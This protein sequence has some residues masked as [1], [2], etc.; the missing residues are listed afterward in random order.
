MPSPGEVQVPVGYA[1][2][3]VWYERRRFLPAI[4]S[5]SFCAVL[6]TVQGGL[7]LGMLTL[8]SLAIDHCRADVWIGYPGAS[9]TDLGLPIP[10]AWR[11]HLEQYPEIVRTETYLIGYAPWGQPGR[12]VEHCTIMGTDLSDDALGAVDLLDAELRRR[13]QEPETVAVGANDRRFLGIA[14]EGQIGEVNGCRAEVVGFVPGAGGVVSSY[15]FCSLST[16]RQL[17]ARNGLGA[18]QTSFILAE[19]RS[20]EDA[21]RLVER[22]RPDPNFSAHTR[23]GFSF[24]ARL[25]WLTRSRFGLCLSFATFLGMVVGLVVTSQTLSGAVAA[26]ARELAVLEALGLPTWRMAG[27]VL[28]QALIVGI[29]GLV[30]AVPSILGLVR[31][32]EWTGNAVYLPAWF[33]T[34]ASGLTLGIALVSGVVALRALRLAE[35]VRLLR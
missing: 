35:P 20:P 2:R 29:T 9:S 11:Y 4:V 27:L 30:L 16:A 8:V 28:G 12:S 7:L 24:Q 3:I 10:A 17:L 14:E 33:L 15:V 13:L 26:A 32:A 25:H 5:V 19:C 31:A 18:D 6:M 23:A 34:A 1:L 21:E 22:L